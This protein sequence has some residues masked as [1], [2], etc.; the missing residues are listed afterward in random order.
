MAVPI[1]WYGA[2]PYVGSPAICSRQYSS[3]CVLVLIQVST[4]DC[5]IALLMHIL[6]FSSVS[7]FIHSLWIYF[8]TSCILS[9][10][11]DFAFGLITTRQFQK[12]ALFATASA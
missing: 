4:M 10:S 2:C 3:W 6:S 9:K 8:V 5:Y 1:L 7:H 11:R 12:T